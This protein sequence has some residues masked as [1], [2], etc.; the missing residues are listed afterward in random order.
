LGC[1]QIPFFFFFSLSAEGGK[2][3]KEGVFKGSPLDK[4]VTREL[5]SKEGEKT[6][7]NQ[8]LLF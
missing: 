6:W 4:K 7:H 8:K 5:K 2:R 3:E 1:P